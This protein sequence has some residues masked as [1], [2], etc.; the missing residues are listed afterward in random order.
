ME[1]NNPYQTPN[2]DLTHRQGEQNVSSV[3]AFTV[4][5]LIVAITIVVAL[6]LTGIEALLGMDE[7]PGTQ[8]ISTF[9]P[10]AGAGYYLANKHGAFMP[11][12]T[13]LL[14]VVYLFLLSAAFAAFMFT[15][16]APEI[17][18][19]LSSMGA[20]I[21]LIVFAAVAITF[22]ATYAFI[23]LGEKTAL[24]QGGK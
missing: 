10:A 16:V 17:L 21:W 1:N 24:Q 12:R 11:R 8:F 22:L 9:I 7:L 13:R 4:T 15:L 3:S 19:S 14:A 5:G 2:A 20:W 23:Y 18:A 6:L